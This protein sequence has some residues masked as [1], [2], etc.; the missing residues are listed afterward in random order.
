MAEKVQDAVSDRHRGVELDLRDTGVNPAPVTGTAGLASANSS[1]LAT[2][3]EQ[4]EEGIVI[5][6]PDARI[7]YVNPAFCSMTGYSIKEIIG[8]S[9]RILKSDMQKV[10]FYR[11]LWQT[12]LTGKVW[13]GELINRRK[14]GTLYTAE[15]TITPVRDCSGKITNYIAITQ[16][17]TERRDAE[18]ALKAAEE[19]YRLLFERNQAGLF[20][21]STDQIIIDAND[22]FAAILG[23][24]RHEIVGLH[25]K[26]IVFD[27]QESERVWARLKQE[28][29]LTNIESC[30]KRK[31]GE[32]VWIIASLN[33]VEEDTAAPIVHGSCIE[34]TERKLAELTISKAKEAAEAANRAK[35]QFLASMSHEIRTPMNGVIGMTSLLLGTP[36][37][38]EQ[39]QY[40]EIVH[41]SGKTLLGV[42]NNI[43]DFSKIEARRLVLETIDFDL[44]IPLRE[45]TEIVALEAHRKGLELT[46]TIGREVP[47]LVK[48]DPARLRQILINLLANAVKFTSKGEIALEVELQAE[49]GE[50]AS[51]R[52]VVKDT[53]IGFSP[54][55]APFL[56]AP[57]TQADGSY[58][59]RYGGTGLGLTICKQ[60]VELM[61]GR[62]GAQ[63]SAGKGATFWFTIAFEKQHQPVL[64]SPSLGLSLH[65]PKVLIV[66]DNVRNRALISAMLQSCG[67]RNEPT[68]DADSALAAL[69]MAASAG[70]PFRIALL[71]WKM[72]GTDGLKLGEQIAADAELHDI[73]LV[74]MIPL[75]LESDMASLTQAG[76]LGHLSKPVWESSLHEAI[77]LASGGTGRSP[78]SRK[79]IDTPPTVQPS[80]LAHTRIL[81]VEDN[82]TNQK[83]AAAILAKLGCRADIVEGGARAINLLQQADYDIVFMDCEM[84]DMDGYETARRIRDPSNQIRNSKVPII[85][86]TAHALQGDREKCIAAGMSDYLSKPIEPE[87][88]SQILSKWLQKPAG[89]GEGAPKILFDDK[90][91]LARLSGDRALAQKILAGF[92]GDIPEQLKKLRHNIEQHDIPGTRLLAH[93]LKGAMATVS[94]PALQAVSLEVYQSATDADWPRAVAMQSL[95]EEEFEQLKTTL[96]QSGWV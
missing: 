76:F 60:L 31:N 27:A 48:G 72:P 14:D 10:S 96:S 71:D 15:M 73:G 6:D 21:Y 88:L 67:C 74:L 51:L 47:S 53:G 43:L 58:T 78:E 25:R 17:V 18:E 57:F 35:S 55:Q 49:Y 68:E 11:D 95:L 39:R 94:A 7:Q 5:T 54:N 9:T 66:D 41:A 75:G 16:D 87:Q 90:G 56:F 23:Y 46:C 83:V 45:A 80:I 77:K 34:I 24:S 20:R 85:A 62:I 50:V 36:L 8:E 52:F 82:P 86:L 28:R 29:I 81:V 59:R 19:H 1:L 69:H 64:S 12:I 65:P 89:G 30:L 40:V 32:A 61:R 79:E 3:I 63:S 44:R 2:A 42:I 91:L 93:T 92:L 70:D 33:W 26:D 84:P 38:A 22:A 4:A 37:N 13:R